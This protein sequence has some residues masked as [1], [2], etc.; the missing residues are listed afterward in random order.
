M[1]LGKFLL[2][3]VPLLG[4]I[5]GPLAASDSAGVEA[6][7]VATVQYTPYAMPRGYPGHDFARRSAPGGYPWS[8]WRRRPYGAYAGAAPYEPW[9]DWR[10]RYEPRWRGYAWSYP[11]R[12]WRYHAQDR[13]L[14]D[15]R[16]LYEAPRRRTYAG[17]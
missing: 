8:T 9:Y 12:D 17:W 7:P 2:L 6:A 4:S 15:P 5:S 13:F 3:A 11:R 14:V 10:R 1:R 16:A